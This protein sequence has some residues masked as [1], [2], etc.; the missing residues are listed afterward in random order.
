MLRRT[1]IGDLKTHKQQFDG[2]SPLKSAAQIKV[3]VLIAHGTKDKRV[4]IEHSEK[5]VAALKKNGKEFEWIE[6]EGEGH[7][8]ARDK[9]LQRF[10]AELFR[11][12]EK[13][14]GAAPPMPAKQ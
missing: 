6:L 1:T 3:P 12:L 8:I 9:N 10:Y 11:F 4:P 2:V 5:L 13:H 7:G 14:I